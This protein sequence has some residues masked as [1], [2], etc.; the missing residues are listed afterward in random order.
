MNRDNS[1]I[2]FVNTNKKSEKSP[3]LKGEAMVNGRKYEIAGWKRS[4]DKCAEFW[5]GTFNE[6]RVKEEYK[7]DP[8][9]K[10]GIPF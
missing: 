2:I 3:D 1:W 10:D 4:S 8:N 7:G 5:T 9:S 6:P